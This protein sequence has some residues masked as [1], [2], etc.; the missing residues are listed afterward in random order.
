MNEQPK[1][2]ILKQAATRK[3]GH[4]FMPTLDIP[5]PDGL[6]IDGYCLYCIVQ[7]L[8]M[9]PCIKVKVDRPEDWK[10]KNKIKII[11]NE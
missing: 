1:K 6:T 5:M 11:F 2:I 3:C 7:K 10:D 9:K 8:G 4:P